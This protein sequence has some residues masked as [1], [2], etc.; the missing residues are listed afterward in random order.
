MLPD[1]IS[2]TVRRALAEDI[3]SGDLTA[4]LI[5]PDCGADASVM[6]RDNAVLCGT[7]WFDEVFHQ[8]DRTIHVSWQAQDSD[9]IRAGQTVCAIEGPARMILTGER[10]ALN[11]LQLL[12]GVATQAREYV[13]GVRGTPTKILDTRKTVPGLRKAQKYAVTCGGAQNHRMGLF[14]GILI[15]ENHILAAGSIAAAVQRAKASA[16]EGTPIEVEV[17]S[18]DE[19][20]QAIEA[21]ADNLLLDNFSL[22]DL[23]A[24][25]ERAHGRA[26]LE[27][28]GGITREN[29][30]QIA[31]TGVD[32]ISV[33]D[34]T[35]NVKAVDFSMRFA[36]NR[37]KAS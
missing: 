25:V 23:R 2:E 10:M 33:G 22:D 30:R 32:Y 36:P 9:R 8:L 20:Q 14:D 15:K 12:S 18:L 21:G 3:G 37:P 29:V 6:T 11:F 34:L 19:L 16:P 5:P 7:A 4:A 13:D 28:S 31:E 27:A 24:A 26:T 35:K 17:E 1:D